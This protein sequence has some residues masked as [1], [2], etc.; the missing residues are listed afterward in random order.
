MSSGPFQNVQQDFIA[1]STPPTAASQRNDIENRSEKTEHA[2]QD[3]VDWDGPDDTEK[4]INWPPAKKWTIVGVLSAITFVSPLASSMFAPGVSRVMSEFHSDNSLLAGFV[5]SVY[6]LGYAAG[7]LIVAPMSELYGR[8]IIYNIT[9]VLFLIFTIACGVSS[10]LGMLIGFRLLAGAVGSTPL[11]NGGGTLSDLFVQEERGRAIA[12]WSA[13]PMVGPVIGP[14]AGGFL[15]QAVGWRWVFWLLTMCAAI[16]VLLFPFLVHETYASTILERKTRRIRK[17]TGNPHLRS[18]L[19]TGLTAREAFSQAI[20][21]PAKIFFQ[22][23]VFFLSAYSSVIYAYLYLM[24]TT[25]PSVF[26][27]NYGFTTGTVGLAY[28]GI[29]VGMMLALLVFGSTSDR[30]LKAM[31]RR[32]RKMEPEFRLPFMAPGALLIPCGL[33]LYGW[34]AEYHVHWIVPI[35]GTALVGTG[36]LV[37][38]ISIQTYLVDAFNR[39]ASSALAANAVLR[40][41]VGALLPLAGPSMYKA[42]GLGWGNSLLGFIAIAFLP[43]PFLFYMY[44]ERIRKDPRFQPRL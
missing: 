41:L 2:D 8:N 44:G 21:R 30:I 16:P 15:A 20:A 24:F 31:A 22:P 12:I 10:N 39:L 5:V 35:I 14:I 37:I 18:K 3:I 23:I 1:L 32:H 11:T 19:D 43:L 40:S 38:F 9:N 42:L 33:F 7:P 13:G 4:P 17:Q 28:I 6:V 25:I 34:S 29:G 26:E 36:I 27:S